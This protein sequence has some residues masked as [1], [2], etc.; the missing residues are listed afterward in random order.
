MRYFQQLIIGCISLFTLVGCERTT[1][2]STVPYAPV[3]VEINT[4][5]VFTDFLPENLNAYIVVN[6][7]GYKENGVFKLPVT[8]QDAWGYGGIV[9]YVSMA[10]YVAYDL[11]CPYCYARGVKSACKMHGIYAVCPECGEEYELGSGMAI[12]SKGLSHETLRP[13]NVDSRGDKII[14]TQR[15]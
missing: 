14:I 5:T 13:M 11:T 9:T 8:Y 2:R 7:E 4:K 1:F 10:G 15:P 12:P 6:E 3:H